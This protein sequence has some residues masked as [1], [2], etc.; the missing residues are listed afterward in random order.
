MF[1][2][3]TGKTLDKGFPYASP[4]STSNP[5]PF[6]SHDVNEGDWTSFLGE[7][8]SAATLTDKQLRLSHLP[9]VCIIPIVNSLSSYGVKQFMKHQNVSKAII[10]IDKW[11]RHFFEPRKIRI[12][13]MKGQVKVKGQTEHLNDVT[14]PSSSQNLEF[15]DRK[16]EDQPST[17]S[18]VTSSTGISQEL[19]DKNDDIYRLFLYS[20]S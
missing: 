1:L 18:A 12:V 19:I 9:I 16:H 20:I 17:S 5:H 13:L 3:A 4:P 6:V 10:C 2:V 11:N 7:V 8:Q 14:S 15:G